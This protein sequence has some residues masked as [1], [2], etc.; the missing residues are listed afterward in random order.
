MP[1]RQYSEDDDISDDEDQDDD[2]DNEEPLVERPS[3]SK[4]LFV[5]GTAAQKRAGKAPLTPK[6][7]HKR[8]KAHLR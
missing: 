5:R 3:K 1:S 8:K 6:V 2:D 4:A 7:T